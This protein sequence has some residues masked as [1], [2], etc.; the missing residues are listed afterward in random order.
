MADADGGDGSVRVDGHEEVEPSV[1]SARE[2]HGQDSASSSQEHADGDGRE[3]K[4]GFSNSTSGN[5]N[6][7]ASW[8]DWDCSWEEDRHWSDQWRSGG[9]RGWRS[10][11]HGS[12]DDDN[13]WGDDDYQDDDWDD[14]SH[15]PWAEAWKKK[16]EDDGARRHGGQR[17]H[18]RGGDRQQGDRVPQADGRAERRPGRDRLDRPREAAAVW[19][20]WKHFAGSDKTKS[21]SGTHDDADSVKSGRGRPSEKLIVPSFSGEDSEDVGTSA[22]S[23]LR[24]VEAWRRMTLLPAHQQ[25]LVLYQHLSG[26]AWVAA[27]ELNMDSLAADD[28]AQYLIKWVTNRYLDLEVTRIGKAGGQRWKYLFASQTAAGRGDT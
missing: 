9:W 19:N 4:R 21:D 16:Q 11:W 7:T 8:G 3:P 2:E 12:W 10:G 5:W 20:G 26:K 1:A 14:W 25:G 23:Y 15:D 18:H 6:S 27:E 17:E 13:S 22:R 24:Q 28:G